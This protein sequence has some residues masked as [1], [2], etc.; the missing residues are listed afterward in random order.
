VRIFRAAGI[1][2]VAAIALSAW[3]TAAGAWDRWPSERPAW[4]ARRWVLPPVDP[5]L[6]PGPGPAFRL[7]HPPGLP[8]SYTEPATGTTYCFA[9]T[10]GFYFVCGYSRPAFE[11]ADLGAALG[12]SAV[13]LSGSEP[14]PA[15]S[16]VLFFRLPP[17]TEAAV[18]GEWVG[19]SGGVGAAAVTPGR[20]RI[21]IRTGGHETE[22]IVTI[23][24]RT[25]LTV[26]P[27]G[28]TPVEP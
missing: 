3:V 2:V 13:S 17:H 26:T 7:F 15:P 14:L 5:F 21:V 20:H 9:R 11:A 23:A 8:L 12:P 10:T 16:G 18:D 4:A 24:S 25:I 27:T 1:T 28:I 19:L 22:Q 6:A